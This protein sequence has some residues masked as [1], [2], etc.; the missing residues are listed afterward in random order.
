MKIYLDDDLDSNL[1]IGFLKHLGHAP[2]SPRSVKTRGATDGQHLTYAASNGLVLLSAN[3]V[4][5]L[6]L[7][8]DW[9]ALDQSHHG[10]LI[11]YRENDPS[12]DMSFKEIAAAVTRI[13]ESGIILMNTIQNLNF[14]R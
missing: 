4:D 8:E 14:W 9:K 11:V 10:I 5:F 6:K 13:Q 3:A 12:R 2:V 1:L 7:H